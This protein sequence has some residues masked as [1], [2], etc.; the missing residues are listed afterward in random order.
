MIEGY[1]Q[2]V[3]PPS[4]HH[5]IRAI[6]GPC[7]TAQESARATPTSLRRPLWIL[8]PARLRISTPPPKVV[9][10]PQP[11]R[12]DGWGDLRGARRERQHYQTRSAR[13]LPAELQRPGGNLMTTE[14]AVSNRLGIALATDSAVTIT[15]GG[16]VKIFDTAD[17]LFELSAQHPVAVMFNGNMDCLGVPWEILVKDFRRAEGECNRPTIAKWADDFL[18]YV[19]GHSLVSEHLTGGYIENVATKEIGAVQGRVRHKLDEYVFR[20]GGDIRKFDL[21]RVVLETIEEREEF[22][23]NFPVATSLKEVTRQKVHDVYFDKIHGEIE[24]SVHGRRNFKPRNC[25]F[26]K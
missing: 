24:N 18:E 4:R 23:R 2:A 25:R 21:R 7:L 17:K 1:C 15:G 22:L 10:I 26:G 14:I 19:Q 20:R 11:S 6:L 13:R 12:L 8:L 3:A 9:R 16:R 5:R